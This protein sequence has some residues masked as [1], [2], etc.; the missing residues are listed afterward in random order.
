VVVYFTTAFVASAVPDFAA[1]SSVR[2][3]AA[4]NRRSLQEAVGEIRRQLPRA[5]RSAAADASGLTQAGPNLQKLVD[6]EL[7]AG[8]LATLYA[9]FLSAGLARAI[10]DFLV[11]IVVAALAIGLLVYRLW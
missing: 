1:W 8:R 3:A 2:K 10:L 9:V 11:P 4:E 5:Q 7:H 6:R